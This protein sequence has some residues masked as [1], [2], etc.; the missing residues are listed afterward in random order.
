MPW[1]DWPLTRPE[2]VPSVTPAVCG[3]WPVLSGA[4]RKGRRHLFSVGAV[5][6]MESEW[7]LLSLKP[8]H[9]P[10]NLSSIC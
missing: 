8:G 2:A 4:V 3:Q 5:S 9:S 1:G 6:G 10:Y 7:Y